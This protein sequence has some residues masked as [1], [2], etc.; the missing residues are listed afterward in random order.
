[1]QLEASADHDQPIEDAANLALEYARKAGADSADTVVMT[2]SALSARVRLG[3]LESI[4]RDETRDLGLRVFVGE[5]S[6]IVSTNDLSAGAL[7]SLAG[8]AVAMAKVAPPDPFA[9]LAPDDRLARSWPDLDLADSRELTSEEL[10]GLATAAEHAGRA[11]NGIT[12]SGG[13]SASYGSSRFILATSAG[14][15]GGYSSTR[16]GLSCSVVAGEGTGMQSDYAYCSRRHFDELDS[17]EDIGREAGERAVK[18]LNP[19]RP[20][21]GPVTAVYEPRVANSLLGHLSGAINGRS[22]ARGTSFLKDSLDQ[23][24]FSSGITITDDPLKQRGP[25]SRPFDAEGMACAPVMM[26]DSGVLTGWLLDCSAARQLGLQ[27]RAQ[28]SRGIG[29]APGPATSNF[30]MAPGEAT[31]QDLIAGIQDG[32]YI[33]GLIGMGVNSVTG[34]YSRGITGFKIENGALG[35]AISEVTIAGNLKDMFRALVP[36]NDLKFD[37]ATNAPT[38]AIEGLTLAGA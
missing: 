14:F 1:M 32:V 10:Q 20:K 27:P 36:A 29:S 6:A 18:A 9:G 7:A 11:V 23:P 4:E 34:D 26:V 24:V 8:R 19:T 33:T 30:Y 15:F 38:I 31:P 21:T 2:G 25:A 16:Y 13:G 35:E 22:I 12:N 3:A 28:A 37:H 5:S 17:P